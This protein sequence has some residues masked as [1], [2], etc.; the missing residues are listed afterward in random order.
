MFDILNG[1]LGHNDIGVHIIGWG[2]TILIAMA[3]ILHKGIHK[4]IT[5]MDAELTATNT[6]L[7]NTN[8]HLN[9]LIGAHNATHNG[10]GMIERREEPREIVKGDIT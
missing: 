6:K 4:R 1:I 10:A 5:Q 2:V 9:Q 7:D 3:T 8:M